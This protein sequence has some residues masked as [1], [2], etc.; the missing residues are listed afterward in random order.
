MRIKIFCLLLFCVCGALFG[1]E[2]PDALVQYRQG[3]YSRAVEI[4][5]EELKEMPRN[6]NSYVVLCWS[7]LRL[8]RDQDAL[9][10]GNRGL[11]VSRYDQR[12]I[13]IVGEA[14]YRLGNNLEALT[15]FE[16]YVAIAPTGDYIGEVYHLMGEIF[17]RLGEWNNAD[18]AF[19]TAVHYN[20]NIAARWARLGYARQQAK[21]YQYALEAYNKALQLNS[22]LTEAIRGRQSVQAILN[23][24]AASSAPE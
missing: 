5:L 18:I 20:P 21:D 14:N 19:S 2:R 22:N 1:Q 16:E 17:I 12:I 10:Y 6:M 11:S 23:P 8:G 24:G 7:L 13:Q 4:C 9:T 3:N 15:Y